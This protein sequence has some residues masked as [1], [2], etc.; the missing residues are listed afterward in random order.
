[1]PY[2]E[3]FRWLLR[4]GGRTKRKEHGA[5]SE[6]KDFGFLTIAPCLVSFACFH[7]IT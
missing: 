2:P 7:L 4:G 5:K 1:M 6:A 3:N